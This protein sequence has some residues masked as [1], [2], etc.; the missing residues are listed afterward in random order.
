MPTYLLKTEP[1]DY[2]YDDLARDRKTVWDGVT[3]PAACIVAREVAEGDE[4]FIYHTGSEK[5]VVG[6]A[7]IASGPRPDP[8]R[9]DLTADGRVK[10]PVFDLR[11]KKRAGTPV[12]LAQLKADDRFAGFDLIRLPRQ[13]VLEVP[14]KLDRL[15]RSMAG[16]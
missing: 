11:A 14:A 8:E 15:I 3:N 16:L 12:T 13:S 6:L 1:G 5:A 9:P 4:A 10:Y 7:A 2:A